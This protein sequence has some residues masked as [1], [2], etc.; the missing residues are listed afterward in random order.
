[1]NTLHSN[2][3][4]AAGQ[5]TPAEI[6]VPESPTESVRQAAG[7]F[8]AALAELP[9]SGPLDDAQAHSLHE[10]WLQLHGA[11]AQHMPKI[12]PTGWDPLKTEADAHEAGKRV[13][14][15][16]QL[17]AALAMEAISIGFATRHPDATP[18]DPEGRKAAVGLGLLFERTSQH[19]LAASSH[20]GH[21][22]DQ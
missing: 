5:Y 21:V 10:A 14:T 15:I 3:E 13:A 8:C 11:M 18:L 16:H 7:A 9:P 22:S 20:S 19:L 17:V 1:M 2:Q 6:N 12:Q 4:A